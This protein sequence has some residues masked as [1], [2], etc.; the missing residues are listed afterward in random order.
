ML[1]YEFYHILDTLLLSFLTF[2]Q[3]LLLNSG[4]HLAAGT[5]LLELVFYILFNT[6]NVLYQLTGL[7]IV[8]LKGSFEDGMM[9]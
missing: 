8:Y 4:T 5:C 9:R 3:V 7:R 2:C 1:K 6:S